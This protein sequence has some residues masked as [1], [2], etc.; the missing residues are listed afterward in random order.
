MFLS[1]SQT[2]DLITLRQQAIGELRQRNA[3][4][5]YRRVPFAAYS[6]AGPS[7]RVQISMHPKMQVSR[8]REPNTDLTSLRQAIDTHSRKG[9][10]S[11]SQLRP[12]STHAGVN[13]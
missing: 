7:L 8:S 11:Y 13:S 5:S 3:A 2:T 4:A 10:L 9:Q 1:A 12:V 6:N